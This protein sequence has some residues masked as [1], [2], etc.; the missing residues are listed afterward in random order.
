[1]TYEHHPRLVGILCDGNLPTRSDKAFK[2]DRYIGKASCRTCSR[3][4][5]ELPT[6]LAGHE[7]SANKQ[8]I[9]SKTQ[10]TSRAVIFNVKR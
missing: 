9:D 8:R 7:Q 10:A 5:I 1:M 6:T 2:D 4:R 3:N